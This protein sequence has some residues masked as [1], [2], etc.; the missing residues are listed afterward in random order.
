MGQLVKGGTIFIPFYHFHPLMNIQ[1]FICNFA[2][3]IYHVFLITPL[4]ITRLLLDEI[5]NF[6][7]LPFDWVLMEC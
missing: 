2:Y 1:T 6:V 7:E 3:E 4:V 5:Y